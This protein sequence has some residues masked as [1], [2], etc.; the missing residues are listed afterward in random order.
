MSRF[1]W[2]FL[3]LANGFRTLAQT[4]PTGN[5]S[6]FPLLEN[7]DTENLF[8]MP[9]CNG[10]KL[11]EATIDQMQRAMEQGKL[12]SV[13]LTMCYLQRQYQIDEYVK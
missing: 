5:F 8:P 7:V 11:E 9:D 6:V 10:F 2:L 13:Q 4:V 1:R 3:F 12:S